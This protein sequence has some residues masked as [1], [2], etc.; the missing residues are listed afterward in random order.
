M[1]SGMG[2]KRSGMGLKWYLKWDYS[3]I[4]NGT[5]V[6]HG[7]SDNIIG[8]HIPLHSRDKLQL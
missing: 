3:G 2:L 8:P 6:T 7:E 4:W 5:R 1:V